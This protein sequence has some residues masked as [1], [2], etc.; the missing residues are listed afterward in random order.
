MNTFQADWGEIPQMPKDQVFT[1]QDQLTNYNDNMMDNLLDFNYND[2]DALLSEE[3][4]DL[5]I[6]LAPSPRDLNMNAEQSLNWMQDIQG[7]RS[8]KPSMSHKRGMSGTAI[9]GF[10]NHNKTL[11]IASFS[12]NTD[13]INEAENENVKGNTDNQNGFV[14]SQVLLKQ[15]EELRL[16]LEKQ[17]EVNRNLERQ[18][19]ENRLQQEH[20]QRVL[21]DQ[22]AVTSQLTAQ[23]V[24][25]SPSKQRSPTKYQ[26]DDAIIVTK[27]SSS[28]GYVFPPPPRVT[29]NNEAVTPPLSFSRFS[30]IDQ[31]ESSDPLNYLQPNGDFTEA[32]ASHKTPESSFGKEHA[33]VLSTSE[34]LRPTNAAR[35]S[36]SKA[37]YSSPN[38]MISPHRKKD[39]VLSTVSTILQP[40]DDYQNTA[41]PPSQMLNLQEANL[42]NEQ[43]NNG[44]ML[45]APVEIMP[46]IPGSKN[47]TPMTANKSGF[48]PQKHTFQHTPVKAKNNVDMNER[49]LVRPELSGTPLNKS[50]QNGMHF[51]E[52]D[53]SNIL[54]H[55]SEIPQGS[56]SHNNTTAGD[57][58]N[59]SNRLQFSNT[60]SSPSRQ[61]KKP[62]TLPPGY[63]DR[64]VK[65]LPDKNFE[66][67]FPNCGKFFRR[68]YN[69]KSHIQTHLE[70]KPYKCDFEGCTK[71]FVRNHDL[72]RHKKTHDKHFSCPCGKKFSSEQSMMKHKNRHNCTGPARVPDSKMVSKSPRKQSS[73]TK[74]SSAI[75]NSPIKENY[76]KENTNLHIDQL[77]M[78]P[79]MRNALEDGGL[80]KPVERTEAMAFPSP[81]SGYSDLGSPF[82]DLGTIEE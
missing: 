23:N 15:Q 44:K 60:E 40:Q 50:V 30:N 5:D 79:K 46:T 3:L 76:L 42:E 34:F 74:L 68:R 43:K 20:I 31:M 36:S 53:D 4:K 55:I 11:S 82:R 41:S 71:A 25:E 27:N 19:R 78:D 45:R 24:T 63:I 69:I 72:A 16:A 33:S 57:D 67:L 21:H 38:S 80:L 12:K 1:P 75:M 54:H 52:E 39:S 51:R 18:L 77:R 35:E 66:C 22:E 61:R 81:L 10:K 73:P 29:L 6:P 62:T 7:H 70:D 37:M 64:Y 8:N 14:L 13:I 49:S 9:F 59:V 28:G 48:M 65:E 56:T 26:G 47:N 2:V 32:Y 58:S 17:K